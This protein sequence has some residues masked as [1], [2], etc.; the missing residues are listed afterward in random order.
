MKLYRT[1]RGAV[2]EDHGQFYQLSDADWDA[3]LNR[4]DLVR[5]LALIQ[6]S[7]LPLCPSKVP[8]P[9]LRSATNC[10]HHHRH[11]PPGERIGGV[12]VPA[13]HGAG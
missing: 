11:S 2:A 12:V 7:A 9:R 8:R 5:S 1:R 13:E 3:L 4:P 10:P 6:P